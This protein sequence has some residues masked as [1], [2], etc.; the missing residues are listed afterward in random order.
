MALIISTDAATIFHISA[1]AI[2]S[3]G[4]T[5]CGR[6]SPRSRKSSEAPPIR[7]ALSAMGLMLPSI[8]TDF[9]TGEFMPQQRLAIRMAA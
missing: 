9:V 2:F 1:R 3:R 8:R 4:A 7:M 5:D 6:N